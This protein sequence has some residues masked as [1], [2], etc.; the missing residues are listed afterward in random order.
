MKKLLLGRFLITICVGLLSV[1]T[2]TSFAQTQALTI[3]S[4]SN[5]TVNGMLTVTVVR[6]Y[7]ADTS[8]LSYTVTNSNGSAYVSNDGILQ[9]LQAGDITISVSSLGDSNYTAASANQII[10]IAKGTPTLGI[11]PSGALVVGGSLTVALSTTATYFRGGTISFSIVAGSGSATIDP[12]IDYINTATEV[13]YIYICY[14]RLPQV[15]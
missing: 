14:T 11:R 6:L 7:P 2:S 4:A 10:S 13:I 8:P 9:G 15:Q 1:F 3:T 12:F 5:L